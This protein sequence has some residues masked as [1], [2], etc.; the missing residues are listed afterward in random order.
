M[1]VTTIDQIRAVLP[2]VAAEVEYADFGTFLKDA[3]NW[4]ENEILGSAIYASIDDNSITDEKLVRLVTNCIV[5]KAYELGIPFMDLIQTQSGFGV[6]NDKNRAPAS[7]KRVERL[8]SQNKLRLDQ[9]IEWL[10]NHLEDTA[11]YHTDW[12][13]SP[14]YSLLSDCLIITARELKRYVKFIGSRNDF[15]LLKPTLITR[16]VTFLNPQI[17]KAY[18]EELIV[19]QNVG[20]LSAADEKVLPGIKQALANICVTEDKLW[21]ENHL[22]KQLL[23]DVVTVIDADIDN[24]ATYRDSPEKALKDDPGYENTE[25]ATI[26]VFKGGI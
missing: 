10:I 24:Y 4:I 1:I 3:E 16:S 19:K 8:I 6:I 26:F 7:I 15:L 23:A 17:S 22:A 21:W 12:K 2:N 9:D 11:T 18:V 25:D 5:L 14:A 20:T 13:S